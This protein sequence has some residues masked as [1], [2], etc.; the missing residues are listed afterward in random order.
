MVKKE[1]SVF[2]FTG[3]DHAAKDAKLKELKR[4]FFNEQ[5]D[6]FNSDLFYAKELFLQD[7]QE[8]ILSLPL[9]SKKRIITIRS[10]NLL[11]PVI[12]EFVIDFVKNNTGQTILVLD[13]DSC[14]KRDG[15]VKDILP[16][17]KLVSF[18]EEEQ[19]N[20]FTLS[21]QIELKRMDGALKILGKL[22]ED[23]EKPE[24]IL[25]GLRYAWERNTAAIPER[26]K[27]LKLLLSCDL[28]LKTSR[29]KTAFALEKLVVS[30]CSLR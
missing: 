16:Y 17:V 28:D 25:G 11:K 26:K 22:L 18:Q 23:G 19:I 24:R 12:K 3:T 8:K 21:R 14:D 7:L 15:F 2:L 10:A 9:N 5:L 1:I 6:Q 13:M 27:R 20:T 4:Q 29:M 30:L